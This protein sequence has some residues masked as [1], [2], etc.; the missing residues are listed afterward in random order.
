VR[1]KE[2]TCIGVSIKI[3]CCPEAS[4]TDCYDTDFY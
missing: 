4:S 1:E 3:R 2:R